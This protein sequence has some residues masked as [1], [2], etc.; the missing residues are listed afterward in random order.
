M[1]FDYFK[2]KGLIREQGRFQDDVAVA[3]GIGKSSFNL[4]IN[5]H[6]GFKQDEIIRICDVLG[7]PYE[8]IHLYFFRVKKT[9]P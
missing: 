9:A 7:I 8:Q 5:G 3:A 2:L 1:E 4:K 6:F